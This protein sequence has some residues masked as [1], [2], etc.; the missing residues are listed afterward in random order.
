[1]PYRVCNAGGSS[2]EALPKQ[3]RH[4]D[5]EGAAIAAEAR[6]ELAVRVFF[7]D[8]QPVIET[9]EIMKREITLGN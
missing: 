9:L 3:I 4:L 6:L 5:E 8:G 1:L 7:R 2:A